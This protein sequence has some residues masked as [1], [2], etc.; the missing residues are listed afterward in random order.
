MIELFNNG[1][2][3]GTIKIISKS[4]EKIGC[5]DFVFKTQ[6]SFGKA[7]A[8]FE[9]S[10]NNDTNSI[11]VNLPMYPSKII[12]QLLSKMYSA[13]YVFS[14][15]NPSKIILMIK[16]A[17]ELVVKN[18]SNILLELIEL[19][20]GQL[21]NDNWLRLLNDIFGMDIFDDLQKC[22]VD[23]FI[24]EVLIKD[25]NQFPDISETSEEVYN[26]L[27]KIFE[28]Y[29]GTKIVKA[30]I[31]KPVNIPFLNL[32]SDIIEEL[33]S[34]EDDD[35]SEYV[36]Q[37]FETYLPD[38]SEYEPGIIHDEYYKIHDKISLVRTLCKNIQ[39]K[40][41]YKL[42]VTNPRKTTA[43]AYQ[44]FMIK[45]VNNLRDQYPGL[46]KKKYVMMALKKWNIYKYN[47]STS[48]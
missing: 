36:S 35:I 30:F 6:C 19:F 42:A 43:Y 4:G 24:Y 23:Y 41:N 40:L 18:K 32:D 11:E 44:K 46:K 20:K 27:L 28:E 45:E 26:F 10:I 17:D 16:L 22:L 15:T 21:T 8:H 25:T 7:L 37:K 47:N 5:H 1:D 14:N 38:Y 2:N 13:N 9:S 48:L 33:K 12:C 3:N 34:K 39:K 29:H 31:K